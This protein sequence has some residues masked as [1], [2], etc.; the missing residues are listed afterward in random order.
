MMVYVLSLTIKVHLMRKFMTYVLVLS[1][2]LL[3]AQMPNSLTRTQKLYGLSRFWQEVNYNF[4]YLDKVDRE[5]WDEDYKDLLVRVQETSN[6]YEY[7]RLLQKFCATLKDGHTNVYFPQSIQDQIL[8]GS[9][10]D[11]KFILSN[12]EGKPTIT[13]INSS[14][15]KELPIGTEVVRVNGLSAKE[16]MAEQVTPYIA[17]STDFILQDWSI[18]KMFEAP[19]GTVYEVEFL[20][21]NGKSK[22]LQLSLQETGDEEIYP[23]VEETGLLDFRWLKDGTAYLALNS[24][25]YPEIEIQFL[26]KLPELYKAKALIVDLRRNGGGSSSIGRNIYQYLTNDAVIHWS[27][28]ESRNHIPSYKAWGAWTKAEDTLN[29]EGARKSFLSFHDNYR[30]R[31]TNYPDTIRLTEKRIVVP[32]VLLTG[33]STASAAEDFLIFAEK[34]THMTRMGEATFGSTGQPYHFQ[35]PGDAPARVCT[36]KDTYPDG[37]EF[38]G[39]GILPDIEV[40]RSLKDYLQNKDVVLERAEAFLNEQEKLADK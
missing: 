4:V 23:P 14:K 10:G 13:G 30:H 29:N 38:V 12:I 25:A 36:K 15:R 31:F 28:S 1:A 24:F 16:Y 39:V 6:D 18:M 27:A 19:I 35:L 26:E 8:N 9:F 2:N 20:L 3:L 5:Q 34:Q 37:R 21:P 32:T 11:Y 40:K 7:Y 17:A 22:S 33:H